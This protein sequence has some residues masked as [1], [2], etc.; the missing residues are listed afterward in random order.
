VLQVEQEDGGLSEAVVWES[1][2]RLVL[3]FH[4]IKN[5]NKRKSILG[6]ATELRIRGFCKPGCP[7]IVIC[8]GLEDDVKVNPKPYKGTT[9]INLLI[10]GGLLGSDRMEVGVN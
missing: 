6:W 8:E 4:H 2:S 9:L 3:W 1:L 7:G 10:S 5:L